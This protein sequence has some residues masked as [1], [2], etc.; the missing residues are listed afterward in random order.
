MRPAEI[1]RFG[2][3]EVLTLHRMPVRKIDSNVVLIAIDYNGSRPVRCRDTTRL[4]SG[5]A[6]ARAAGARHRRRRRRQGEEQPGPLRD[7]PII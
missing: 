7:C 3:P 2:G 5:R 4:V 6:S 1:D